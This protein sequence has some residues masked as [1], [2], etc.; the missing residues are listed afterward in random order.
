MTHCPS[1]AF[2]PHSGELML[3]RA[4]AHQSHAQPLASNT[5]AHPL[6]EPVPELDLALGRG[7]TSSQDELIRRFHGRVLK[8]ARA[9]CGDLADAED[10]TQQ[11]L[12]ELVGGSGPLLT[13]SDLDRWVER[14]TVRCA[15]D[16]SRKKRHRKWLQERWLV[17][18][19]FPWGTE[20]TTTTHDPVD[21][22]EALGK[23]TEQRR[24]AVLLRHGLGYT[25]NEISELSSTP[26]GTVKD[27]LIAGKK[28]LRRSL[29]AE[30][31]D[32]G[33]LER[34]QLPGSEDDSTQDMAT[35][36]E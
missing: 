10:L 12:M 6:S 8:R 2:M 11:V 1:P 24:D 14:F 9:L 35:A 5:N 26:R 15:R 21:V 22:R 30:L 27:R 25:I 3:L 19:Q 31:R 20:A 7:G 13:A 34:P 17:P 36:A 23:L 28:Q 29:L 33:W 4:K 32:R 16:M 18:G